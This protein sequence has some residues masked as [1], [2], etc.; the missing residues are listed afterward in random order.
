MEL[1]VAEILSNLTFGQRLRLQRQW[2]RKLFLDWGANVFQG[3][4]TAG[5]PG[6]RALSHFYNTVFTDIGVF[7]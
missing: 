2:R 4:Q 3:P 1:S 5:P 7:F 6:A